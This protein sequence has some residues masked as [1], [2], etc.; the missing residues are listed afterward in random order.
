MILPLQACKPSIH[1][2][3]TFALLP[4]PHILNQ[5]PPGAQQL[6][7]PDF[8]KVPHFGHVIGDVII[9]AATVDVPVG[10]LV[11]IAVGALTGL[12]IG[13]IGEAVTRVVVG[14]V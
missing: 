9:D 12:V 11:G 2:C 4:P 13:V 14:V 8:L 3:S 10:T 5:A 7:R 6:T 1:V